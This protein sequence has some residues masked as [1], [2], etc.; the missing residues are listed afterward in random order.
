VC[1]LVGG[2]SDTYM[3]RKVATAQSFAWSL[4]SGA[5]ATITRIG[6]TGPSDTAVRITFATGF[7]KDTLVCVTI[8]G[9]GSSVEKTLALSAILAPPTPNAIN[10]NSGNY[11]PCVGSIVQY[12]AVASAPTTAQSAI[13]V[14]RWT[15]PNFTTITSAVSDSSTIT[16]RYDVG[17]AGGAITAKG[18]S[19]C[20]IAGTA[21]SVT[22]L[23]LPP[24]PATLTSST[25]NFAP[26]IGNSV[27]YTAAA[28][29]PTTTQAALVV[30]RWT[31]PNYT[32]ITAAT[33]DSSTITLR[34]DA[35]FIGG[36]IA[37]KGQTAC[38][39]G[40]TA[41]TVS[42]L[43]LPP[44]PTSITSST[45]SYNA[46]IGSSVTYTVAV[47]VPTT[48]QVAASVYR[49]TKP[50]N[51]VITSAAVDSSSITLQFN[52][53]YTGG[54][55][56]CKG[57][58]VCGAQGTAKSQALTHT[59]CPTGTK[60]LAVKGRNTNEVIAQVYPNPNN[61]N[62]K[63]SIATG[64]ETNE[65]ASIKI[66]DMFGRVV[67]RY[68]AANNFGYINKNVSNNKLSNGIYTVKYTIGNITNTIRMVL[69]K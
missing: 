44:T 62:F 2:G 17:Y 52:T 5:Y 40:G 4:K 66:I 55:V 11:S 39:I 64:I 33:A 54:T 63:I 68:T 27:Q 24:T 25:G 1:S 15:K 38:G 46:C 30:F 50:N 58:T 23:Y 10:A 32:T 35:G 67:D 60:L 48:T 7:T 20:G 47:P 51:T 36:S 13:S 56:T 61:G 12:T 65:T 57:Q 18:Q 34:Y 9:C 53:G 43:Y 29:A 41:K 59:A 14:F 8:N 37:V 21:K 16:L 42:L 31:K 6:G 28:P 69:Q 3:I 49:W 26:C 19:A 45:A 22:L